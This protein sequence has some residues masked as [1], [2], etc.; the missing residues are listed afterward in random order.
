MVPTLLGAAVLVFFLLRLIPG[1]VCELRMAGE[2]GYVDEDAIKTC[3][4]DLGM[5]QPKIVQFY[6]F[7]SG[8]VVFDLG[9][10]MWTGKAVTHELGLRFQLSLQVAI[11]ATI[12]VVQIVASWTPDVKPGRR[13]R[14]YVTIGAV[15][16]LVLPHI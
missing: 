1:D 13:I 11:M 14:L 10:S 16:S 6:D 8:F 5:N 7:I 12:G 2:G 15:S 9:E 3:Q 4:V